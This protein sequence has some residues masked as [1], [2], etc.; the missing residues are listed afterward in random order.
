MIPKNTYLLTN[1]GW[2]TVQNLTIGQKIS[3]IHNNKLILSSITNIETHQYSKNIYTINKSPL[4][5]DTKLL[6]K[7][8]RL[9]KI[10]NIKN[11]NNLSTPKYDYSGY[12]LNPITHKK[13]IFDTCLILKLIGYFVE[14]GELKKKNTITFK[15]SK[16]KLNIIAETLILLK[17][18]NF[19]SISN[20]GLLLISYNKYLYDFLLQFRTGRNKHVPRRFLNLDKFYLCYLLEAMLNSSSSKT[21]QAITVSSAELVN[22]IHELI[23]KLGF[24]FNTT[25]IYREPMR[26]EQ[27]NPINY[28]GAP[29]FDIRIIGSPVPLAVTKSKT[30]TTVYSLS[31][32]PD[33][34]FILIRNNSIPLWINLP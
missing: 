32:A 33:P 34:K 6:T 25:A 16:N 9:Q 19:M 31:L 11:T 26:R 28:D 14:C 29:Y 1:N 30:D 5:P 4:L 10:K 12:K 27:Y 21:T 3:S 20:K 18:K 24:S 15:N 22:N 17:I 7:N 8:N 13:L 2:N 23:I